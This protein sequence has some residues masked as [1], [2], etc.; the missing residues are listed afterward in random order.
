MKTCQVCQ[1][2][3][4]D[5]SIVC[6]QENHG[7]LH[8]AR[9]ASSEVV[10]NYRLN[11]LLERD[12]LSETYLANHIITYKTAVIRVV[13]P[14]FGSETH[15]LRECFFNEARAVLSI[16]HPNVIRIYEGGVLDSGEFYTVTE[17]VNG[18]TLREYQ[19]AKGSFS[20]IEAVSIARQIAD[21]LDAVHH[22][23]VLH[24]LLN[25]ANIFLEFDE[26][27]QILPKIQNFDFAGVTQQAIT[28]DE[29]TNN[30]S[31]E[32]LIEQFKYLSPEQCAHREVDARSDIYSLGVVLFELLNGKPPFEAR[33]LHTLI[34]KQ[35]NQEPPPLETRRF[36]IKALLTHTV[37]HSLKKNPLMRLQKAS[38]F[39][40]QLR[41][42]EQLASYSHSHAETPSPTATAH[43]RDETPVTPPH[44]F[45]AEEPPGNHF[46]EEPEPINADEIRF[47]PEEDDVLLNPQFNVT[48]L[49]K[50]KPTPAPPVEN[51]AF[52]HHETNGFE[53]DAEYYAEFE[54]EPQISFAPDVDQVSND[55][56]RTIRIVIPT[57]AP[58]RRIPLPRFSTVVKG[59][60][61]AFVFVVFGI[62]FFAWQSQTP[63]TAGIAA[64]HASQP[65]KSAPTVETAK[66]FNAPSSSQQIPQIKDDERDE[67]ETPKE[68]K[69]PTSAQIKNGNP[70]DSK[71][72][73]ELNSS[74][75]KWL[76]AA[77]AR[78]VNKQMDFYAPKVDAY[79]TTKNVTPEAVRAEKKRTF[80][81]AT[82]VDIKKAG[83][84]EITV[85]KD[86][87]TAKM[88]FRKKYVIKEGRQSRNGEVIQE[89]Q[90]VKSNAGW[91]IVSERDVK[92]IN[93]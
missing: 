76:T 52:S 46:F 58:R 1:R 30:L 22:A 24:R 40:S 44:Q 85:S 27:N 80:E 26:E 15:G 65:E 92:V 57:Q 75:D 23:G 6:E 55:E 10:R 13:A 73:A 29:A 17:A 51:A 14:G 3:Y 34:N 53:M 63:E 21:G 35:I 39:V 84:P 82:K 48:P 16:D 41:H 18:Q 72:E 83:E 67:T 45:V 70:A 66:T 62:V 79:Y 56:R 69:S 36:D 31:E 87:K 7:L 74:L 37:M 60:A 4:D 25:P 93:R 33:T 9:P 89:L 5:A 43:Y 2:C 49:P 81:K 61:A 59:V 78:N 38:Q 47:L 64:T 77:N 54:S 91:K 68:S 32:W 28:S 12:A 71:T 88:R 90:W 19:Q 50:P 86:G 20:E 11:Y 8:P 42:I